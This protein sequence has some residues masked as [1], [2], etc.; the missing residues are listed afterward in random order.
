MFGGEN[1][2]GDDI[3]QQKGNCNKQKCIAIEISDVPKILSSE[4]FKKALYYG[5]IPGALLLIL[6]VVIVCVIVRKRRRSSIS[7]ETYNFQNTTYMTPGKDDAICKDTKLTCHLEEKQIT[8]EKEEEEERYTDM[9]NKLICS[10]NTDTEHYDYARDDED[11]YDT[12]VDESD[13]YEK[14][15][16][17]NRESL[18]ESCTKNA[19]NEFHTFKNF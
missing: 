12:Y 3:D 14:C 4:I 11:H 15:G 8:D 17:V 7:L 13:H 19:S 6:C 10:A 1:C 2:S 5:V 18:D 16:N 9:D